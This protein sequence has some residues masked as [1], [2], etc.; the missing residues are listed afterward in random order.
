MAAVVNKPGPSTGS[1]AGR[2]IPAAARGCRGTTGSEAEP[3][4]PARETEHPAWNIKVYNKYRPVLL[5]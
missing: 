2:S 1:R 3:P 5:L 4:F